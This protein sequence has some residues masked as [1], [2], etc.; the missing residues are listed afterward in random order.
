MYITN[1]DL[2]PGFHASFQRYQAF[3][4]QTIVD[5]P[6]VAI[7]LRPSSNELAAAVPRPVYASHEQRWLDIDQ[8][9][10]ED[11]WTVEHTRLLGDAMPIVWPNMG[12]EIFSAWC[13]AGYVF[14][15]STTWSSPSITEWEQDAGN[16]RLNWEHPLLRATIEYTD[17]LIE[18]GR[19]HFIVGLTDFHPGGDH[20]AALRDPAQLALDLIESPEWVKQVVA[21]ATEEFFQA[22]DLFFDR[23][24]AAGMPATSW[25]PLLADGKFYIPSNDFSALISPQMFE[26]FFLDGIRDEC[27]FLDK[28]IYHLDGPDAVR[29][30]D[31]LLEIPELDAVQFVPGAGNEDLARWMPVYQRIQAAGKSMQIV[32]ATTANIDL[33]MDN[34]RPE[35]VFISHVAGVDDEESAAAVLR[36]FAGWT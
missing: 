20:L 1:F 12:P 17:T 33:L 22:Y 35:G 21:L 27:R 24:S 7:E 4:D 26:E 14:G 9:V 31:L 16:A 28:S 32:E 34:L 36:R 8:R 15:E 23:L 11:V 19:G 18:R 5:R 30:L 29:H 13:G 10:A 2:K 6:L 25:I 3:W